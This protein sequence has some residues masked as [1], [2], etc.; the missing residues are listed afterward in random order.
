MARRSNPRDQLRRESILASSKPIFASR[1][2]HR[3]LRIANL[4]LEVL[5]QIFLGPPQVF[6][7]L[8]DQPTGIDRALGPTGSA[9]GGGLA[10]SPGTHRLASRMIQP[11]SGYNPTEANAVANIGTPDP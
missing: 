7:A 3:H 2:A 5:E 11:A 10:R 6:R 4:C 9:G 8:Q 1:D